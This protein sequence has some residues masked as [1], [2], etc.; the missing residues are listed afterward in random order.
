MPGQSASKRGSMSGS[1][2]PLCWRAGLELL[3]E[4]CPTG[5]GSGF[6]FA[7]AAVGSAVG[8][9][10]ASNLQAALPPFDN[11]GTVG[12]LMRLLVPL[13]CSSAVALQLPA[14]RRPREVS[15]RC[16]ALIAA[17]MQAAVLQS[18]A[19]AG[20]LLLSPALLRT[21]TLL[22]QHAP[23]A[24]SAAQHLFWL[25][26]QLS[27]V[28]REIDEADEERAPTDAGQLAG[29][30]Q[31]I[32]AALPRQ[33]ELLQMLAGS[34]Q[35]A[36]GMAKQAASCLALT[37]T[38]LLAARLVRQLLA[39]NP[40]Q[41]QLNP[42]VPCWCGGAA[43]AL[44]AL[45]A[46]LQTE[47][48]L[49]Q[50]AD[51]ERQQVAPS[52][53]R[54]AG[55]L[56]AGAVRLVWQLAQACLVFDSGV[57][58]LRR[59]QQGPGHSERT[60]PDG[61]AAAAV[62][63]LLALHTHLCRTVHWS[64][65]GGSQLSELAA[66]VREGQ[67]L[68][69]TCVFFSAALKLLNQ[70]EAGTVASINRLLEVASLAPWEVVCTHLDSADSWAAVP[71]GILLSGVPLLVRAG[72]AALAAVPRV[73]AAFSAALAGESEGHEQAVQTWVRLSELTHAQHFVVAHVLTCGLAD[74][75][76]QACMR[77]PRRTQQTLMP[78]GLRLMDL[79]NAAARAAATPPADVAE[80]EERLLAS[81][82]QQYAALRASVEDAAGAA[83]AALLPTGAAM[84]QPRRQQWCRWALDLTWWHS[85]AT[86]G[87]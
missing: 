48:C 53:H 49:E 24:S 50:L 56:A 39:S 9:V 74:A 83:R 36:Q 40:T 82:R 66:F 7:L 14:D 80:S 4:R 62:A 33:A 45:P 29:Q 6:A 79:L 30:A 16:A 75:V 69:L 12:S 71:P 42:H 76:V 64:R 72:P 20:P 41:A 63:A 31:Q 47:L 2:G 84:V 10:A 3:R 51:A 17:F 68:K 25:C 18:L 52:C 22:V 77:E 44:Q 38:V 21:A 23:P 67:L 61:V 55:T 37:N 15:W 54:L 43:A 87:S 35:A 13:I 26:G 78:L 27:T 28:C 65:G 11:T 34:E 58:Q 32:M 8:Q 5:P 19:V 60:P 59:E 46:V 1:A 81:M 73:H 70:A 57:G 85:T 86:D